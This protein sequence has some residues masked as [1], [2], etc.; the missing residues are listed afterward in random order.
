MP[1]AEEAKGEPWQAAEEGGRRWLQ[2]GG[3][4]E[5][6]QPIP[7]NAGQKGNLP[8]Q[9]ACVILTKNFSCSFFLVK[10]NTT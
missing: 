6:H 8:Q 2:G 4:G 7:K 3:S 5:A 1:A 10:L 9:E